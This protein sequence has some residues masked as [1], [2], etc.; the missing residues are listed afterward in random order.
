M[1]RHHLSYA[2]L[3]LLL[4]ASLASGQA[5]VSP[6]ATTPHDF[7][8]ELVTDVPSPTALAFTPDGRMLIASQSGELW[9]YQ[10]GSL[11]VTP[12]LDLSS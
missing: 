1:L 3:A 10:N 9:V 7:S 4:V 2:A 6:A 8:D 11:L 12:A 5:A